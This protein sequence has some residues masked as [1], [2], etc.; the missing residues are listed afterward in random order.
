MLSA[1]GT[2]GATAYRQVLEVALENEHG[3]VMEVIGVVDDVRTQSLTATSEVE[4]YRP[5]LQRQ[6]PA[7]HR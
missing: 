5:V 7:M 2:A 4:F 1:P 6:R 3:Q